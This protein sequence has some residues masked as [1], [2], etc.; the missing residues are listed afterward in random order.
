M[1]FRPQWDDP[2]ETVDCPGQPQDE[3]E[4]G[5]G[6]H[7]PEYQNVLEV[8]PEIFLLEVVAA[9]EDHRGQEA[10]EEDLLVKLTRPTA[11]KK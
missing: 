4:G 6:A 3:P 8:L 7:Q 5:E 11:L 2:V 9:G 10:V 1:A